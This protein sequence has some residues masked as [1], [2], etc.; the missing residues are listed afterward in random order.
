MIAIIGDFDW[1][2]KIWRF[3]L[4]FA[5]NIGDFDKLLTILT[6]FCQNYWRFWL[7]AKHIGNFIENQ[8]YDQY[9]DSISI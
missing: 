2:Q 5:K 7:I 1:L 9:L 6:N 3:W 4:S 8:C